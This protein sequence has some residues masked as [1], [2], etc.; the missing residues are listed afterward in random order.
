MENLVRFGTGIVLLAGLLGA[1]TFLQ[2]PVIEFTQLQIDL[3]REAQREVDLQCLLDHTLRRREVKH[4]ILTDLAQRRITLLEAANRFQ[5]LHAELPSSV[6]Q[7]ICTA[8]PATSAEE[9]YC[10]LV[11]AHL[12]DFLKP[13][14]AEHDGFLARLSETLKEYQEQGI[15]P[16]DPGLE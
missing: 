11:I 15:F 6:R 7:L 4:Q 8:Y 9:R 12:N 13:G 2:G 14:S 5:A 1:L 16:A 10:Q 3:G